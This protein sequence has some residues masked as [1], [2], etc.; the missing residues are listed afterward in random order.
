[1]NIDITRKA[2]VYNN[3]VHIMY[4]YPCTAQ[5]NTSHTDSIMP[6]PRPCKSI[7]YLSKWARRLCNVLVLY[8]LLYTPR[9]MS[10]S[11]RRHNV[12][13]VVHVYIVSP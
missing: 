9:G 8:I 2:R 13:L 3:Y 11:Y 12:A 10:D 6:T 4:I 5:Y 1:M 7:H